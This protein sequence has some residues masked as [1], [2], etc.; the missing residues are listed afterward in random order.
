MN[1]TA[2]TLQACVEQG[3]R[4]GCEVF[5]GG[6]ANAAE[7]VRQG[8]GHLVE[9][10]VGDLDYLTA[11]HSALERGAAQPLFCIIASIFRIWLPM[12]GC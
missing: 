12:S 9:I 4:N 2:D 1:C 6:A 10:P 7:F 3:R 8:Q 5:V 11:L